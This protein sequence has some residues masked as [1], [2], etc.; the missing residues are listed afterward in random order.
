[1]ETWI[2]L[3]WTITN[4]IN[5]AEEYLK[6][7]KAHGFEAKIKIVDKELLTF[8]IYILFRFNVLYKG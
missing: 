5:Q 7:V 4:D 2:L 8:G 6:I 1:M 3:D